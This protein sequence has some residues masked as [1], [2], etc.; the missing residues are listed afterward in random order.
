M[1]SKRI[2]LRGM[3]AAIVLGAQLGIGSPGA[4]KSIEE[5]P[6]SGRRLVNR[7][8]VLVGDGN[9]SGKKLN[10]IQVKRGKYGGADGFH[11]S[12]AAGLRRDRRRDKRLEWAR[13]MVEGGVMVKV[14]GCF[15]DW[16]WYC[17]RCLRAGHALTH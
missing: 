1:Q 9:L 4:Q 12:V 14:A 16:P 11:K 17:R 13:S 2:S 8:G 6:G 15:I 5:R 7:D 3:A 10:K